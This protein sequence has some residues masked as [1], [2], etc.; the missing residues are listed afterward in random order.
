MKT[1]REYIRES[2]EKNNSRLIFN[3]DLSAE[4]DFLDFN[5]TEKAKIEKLK[6]NSLKILNEISEYLCA[7]KINRP[8]TDV[9]G[10]EIPSRRCWMRRRKRKRG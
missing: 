6:N 10:L 2:A 4:I 9:V 7:V 5:E 3:L 1:F 8:F